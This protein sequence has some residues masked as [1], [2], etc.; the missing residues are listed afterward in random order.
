MKKI[1]I[2]T[3]NIIL[4]LLY[5][6][7]ITGCQK[8]FTDNSCG[9]LCDAL[10]GKLTTGE[11]IEPIPNIQI[12]ATWTKTFQGSVQKLTAS[13]ISDD[14]GNYSLNFRT[15]PQTLVDGTIDLEIYIGDDYFNCYQSIYRDK[16]SYKENMEVHYH[17]PHNAYLVI[18]LEKPQTPKQENNM[19]SWQAFGL[20]YGRKECIKKSHYTEEDYQSNSNT[21][22]GIFVPANTP[23]GITSIVKNEIEKTII[24]D[25]FLLEKG[26]EIHYVVKNPQ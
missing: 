18:S 26:D 17:F 10:S 12:K 21:G 23:F 20:Q 16:I 2:K 9:V 15:N 5:F 25:S 4:I 3:L 14:Q 24:R 11:G 22:W 13:T 8:K 6:F 1:S 7:S 19:L